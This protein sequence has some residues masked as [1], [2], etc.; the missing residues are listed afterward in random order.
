MSLVANTITRMV[1]LRFGVILTG[2]SAF[3]LTLEAVSYLN[4]ILRIAGNPVLAMLIYGLARMPGLLSLFLPTSL[5]LSLLLVITELS[6]RNELTAIWATGISP[7]R[8]I[9][10]LLPLALVVGGV[11][12]LIM[13]QA[14]P[15]A[16]PALRG[17]GIGDYATRKFTTNPNDPVWIRAGDDLIR[18]D[19][20]SADGNNLEKAIIFRREKS[21]ELRDQVFAETATQQNGRWLL[22]K[23][24]IYYASGAQPVNLDS[25]VYEGALRLASN[26]VPP[27]EEM[28][29]WELNNFINNDGFGVRPKYVYQTWWNKRLTPVIEAIVMIMLCIPLGTY[30]RRGGGLGGIFV[31][32]VLMG[33]VYF[34]GDGVAMTM[35]ETGRVMPWM[36]AWGP[37]VLFAALAFALLSRTDHV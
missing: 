5:L 17:W 15:A 33:F 7:T 29:I 14:V 21:G 30:F 35:G 27:P 13:D 26:K 22:G 16:A 6:Y 19:S 37:I 18:A 8:L 23:V 10:M 34:V 25:M 11:H 20:I 31:G 32:G 4:D 2:L 1:L 9:R 24:K 12:F 3:V 28:T 36:A